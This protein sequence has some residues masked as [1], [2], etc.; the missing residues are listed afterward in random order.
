VF[1]P[2][3][4][5]ARTQQPTRNLSFGTESTGGLL[6]QPW[7]S[8]DDQ[9]QPVKD[10]AWDKMLDEVQTG[11]ENRDKRETIMMGNK[12]DAADQTKR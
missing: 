2:T 1:L 7:R 4:P 12:R 8:F 6:R 5:I 3:D 11:V 10:M 9:G